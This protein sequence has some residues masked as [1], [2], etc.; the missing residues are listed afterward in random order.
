MCIRD[1]LSLV[2]RIAGILNLVY[3]KLLRHPFTSGVL[4][5]LLVVGFVFRRRILDIGDVSIL[6]TRALINRNYSTLNTM[7]TIDRRCQRVGLPRPRG[8]SPRRWLEHLADAIHSQRQHTKPIE[9]TQQHA[10]EP[11]ICSVERHLYDPA[12]QYTK[13]HS[14]RSPCVAALNMWSW[15]NLAVIHRSSGQLTQPSYS[16]PHPHHQRD[17]K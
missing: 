3:T 7:R 10:A 8:V 14:D 9:S 16:F 12:V 6:R 17:Q 1:R 11:F 5:F 2:E 13:E 15:R 4:L